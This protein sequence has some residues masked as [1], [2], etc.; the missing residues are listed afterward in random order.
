M[1]TKLCQNVATFGVHIVN[2]GEDIISDSRRM[3]RYSS[4]MDN[5]REKVVRKETDEIAGRGMRVEIQ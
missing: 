2:I 4:W 5:I 3:V 1:I